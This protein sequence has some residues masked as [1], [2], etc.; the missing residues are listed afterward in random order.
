MDLSLFQFDYDQSWAAFFLNADLTIYGR[1]GTRSH[2]TESDNDV[3]LN[4]FA[5]ALA[6]ALAM[7]ERF[8]LVKSSLAAKRGPA[9]NV[10]V[11]EEFPSL[12]GRF[13]SKLDYEGQVVQSCIHCHQVGEA[14]RLA[15]R[16][17]GKP[18]PDSVLFPYPHPKSLG[19]ILDPKARAHV[20]RVTP[21]SLAAKAGFQDGDH[22]VTLAGQPLLSTA[23]IQWVLHQAGE[24]DSLEAEVKRGSETVKL[25][26]DLPTGWR[27]LGDI[28]WRATSWELRR[29]VTGGL[30]F[31]ELPDE[32]RQSAGLSESNLAL[33]IK[34]VGQY[35]AHAVGKKAGFQLGDVLIAVDDRSDDLSESGLLAYLVNEKRPGDRVPMTVL[36]DGKKL[37]LNLPIQ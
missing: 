1:Y 8:P 33:R 26:L 12:K 17:S 29:M 19:L 23:D 14:L 24:T 2:Q 18:I 37:V 22:I 6:G 34:H 27:K 13:G 30:V 3:S 36:R 32:Q 28:S 16:A 7:H 4:G 21:D 20:V 11:P 5:E 35:G 10:A 15:A 31:E 25:R 9:S